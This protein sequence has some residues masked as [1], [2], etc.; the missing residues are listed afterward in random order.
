MDKLFIDGIADDPLE[1]V[2]FVP[3]HVIYRFK[4]S[5]DLKCNTFM[6]LFDLFDFIKS[7]LND[8]KSYRV[9]RCLETYNV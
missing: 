2:D 4:D 1:I 6:T 7:N 9:G 5:A 3:Y 8:L